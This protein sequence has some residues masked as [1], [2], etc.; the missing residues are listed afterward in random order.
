MLFCFPFPS[1]LNFLFALVCMS[2]DVRN[3]EHTIK[4]VDPLLPTFWMQTLISIC[5]HINRKARN[6]TKVVR[7]RPCSRL[8]TQG[9]SRFQLPT[10]SPTVDAYKYSVL[11]ML[12]THETWWLPRRSLPVR[13]LHSFGVGA[14]GAEALPSLDRPACQRLLSIL[15]IEMKRG[16]RAV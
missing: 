6:T 7:R 11:R 8:S 1:F 3:F 14:R 15:R 2:V 13:M 12:Y 5:N 16:E 4:Q 9:S 10:Y